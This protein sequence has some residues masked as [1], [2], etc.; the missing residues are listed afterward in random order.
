[1]MPLDVNVNNINWM[2]AKQFTDGKEKTA[3]DIIKAID[4]EKKLV[5]FKIVE[6]DLMQL[7]RTFRITVHVDAK[8]GGNN[9]VT[10]IFE[11]KK[12]SGDVEDPKSLMDFCIVLTK[13]I[14]APHLK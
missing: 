1:M 7:Y 12:L 14:E 8:F 4:E 5:R 10:W 13:D 2:W 11:Y 3:E 6:R 9:L